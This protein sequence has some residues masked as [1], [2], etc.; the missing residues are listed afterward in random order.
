MDPVDFGANFW[1]QAI[2]ALGESFPPGARPGVDTETLAA[3]QAIGRGWVRAQVVAAL[4]LFVDPPAADRL[5]QAEMDKLDSADPV[6]ER[7]K[8]LVAMAP[9]LPERL[10]PAAVAA[11]CTIADSG[12][13]YVSPRAEAFAALSKRLS[14]LPKAD[15]YRIWRDTLQIM[16]GRARSDLLWDLGALA[17]AGRAL[18]G[19]VTAA[20]AIGMLSRILRWWP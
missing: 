20:E 3:A 4:S 17:P 14:A 19:E 13:L 10:L 9:R 18:G 6:D 8:M 15:L 16:A 11:A 1:A 5:F 7:S 12:Y 2:T